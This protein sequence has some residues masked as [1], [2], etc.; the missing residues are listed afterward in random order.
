MTPRRVSPPGGPLALRCRPFP[1]QGDCGRAGS[2]V[3]LGREGAAARPRDPGALGPASFSS[4]PPARAEGLQD[5]GAPWEAAGRELPGAD[6]RSPA[7][8]RHRKL[9]PWE[10]SRRFARRMEAGGPAPGAEPA[11]TATPPGA[12]PA[13]LRFAAAASWQVVRGR[14]VEHFPRVLQFLRSLRAAAPGLV[15]YR[16]HERLCMGLNAK[17]SEPVGAGRQ[18]RAGCERTRWGPTTWGWDW[19]EKGSWPQSADCEFSALHR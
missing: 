3:A 17:V 11:A 1:G 9:R 18:K 10:E 2:G 15:R 7:T 4:R 8:E 6:R 14:C 5:S 19:L 13:A 12:G 16:H